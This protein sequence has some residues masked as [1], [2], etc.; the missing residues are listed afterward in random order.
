MNLYRVKQRPKLQLSEIVFVCCL[1]HF[2]GKPDVATFNNRKATDEYWIVAADRE[3]A[4]T[5]AKLYN[6]SLLRPTSCTVFFSRWNVAKT[7]YPALA[8]LE[9]VT[10]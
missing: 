5:L 2:E 8:I 3:D 1:C 10:I 7:F 4:K 9:S 6:N